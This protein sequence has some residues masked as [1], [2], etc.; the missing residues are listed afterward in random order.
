MLSSV[1]RSMVSPPPAMVRTFP[2]AMTGSPVAPS[3]VL[4]TAVRV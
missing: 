1:L 2:A 3:V 4:S